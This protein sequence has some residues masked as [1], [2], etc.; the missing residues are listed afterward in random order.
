MRVLI[1]D[2]EPLTRVALQKVVRERD[3]IEECNFAGDAVE[4]LARLQE[5]DFDVLMLDI[6]LPELSGIEFADSLKKREAPM[7]SIIFVTAHEQYAVAAFEKHAVDYVLK[8]FSEKRIHEAL[9]KAVRRTQSDRAARMMDLLPQIEGLLTKPC[10]I[11]IKAKGRILFID[12][13]EVATVEAQGN[14]VLLQRKSGS[15]LLR[16]SIS[17]IAEK[18]RPY[19]FVR[20][21]RSVLINASF[22]EEIEPWATGEYVLRIRGGKE[23]TVSR[24]YKKNLHSI[25]PLW[26]GTDG[27]RAG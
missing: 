12:P 27:F 6:C 24:T 26:F 15:D 2:D 17:T 9:D 11:A 1:V 22:V 5:T 13:A 16:E 23:F 18:L 7:P 14:Y 20:I 10:R 3:D 25:T 8:P 19:G 4:A 21:H